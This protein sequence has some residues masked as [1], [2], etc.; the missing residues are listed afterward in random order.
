M[1]SKQSESNQVGAIARWVWVL[2]AVLLA[3]GCANIQQIPE[4]DLHKA[5]EK[6]DYPQA[7]LAAQARPQQTG[8]LFAASTYRPGFEDNRARLIGDTLNIQISETLTASQSSTSAVDRKSD[9][10]ASVSA[11]P[12]LSSS[13]TGKLTTG[14]TSAATF[15]GDG[16]TT[17]ANTFTG[18]IA[19]TVVDVLP[20][21]HLVVVGEKQIG[22]NQNVDVLKFSGTVDPRTIQLGNVVSSQ[23]VANVRVLS[24]GRGAANDA[25]TYGWLSRFF[26]SLW[27]F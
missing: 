21:G 26:L 17:A 3:T 16:T 6:I 5:P 4:V 8:S 14:A 25:Q 2:P 11:V 23:Q 20:N 13:L 18:S 12:F 22:V 10:S 27:P 24:R 15:T 1:M 9:L 19:A 7:Q